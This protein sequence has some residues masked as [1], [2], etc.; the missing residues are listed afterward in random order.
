ME[1]VSHHGCA[2][3]EEA[4]RKLVS[5]FVEHA[6]DDALPLMPGHSYFLVRDEK[7]APGHLR[8]TLAPLLRE[9]LAQGYV[10]GFA[11]SIRGYLQWLES[12]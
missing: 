6:S 4:F 12:R 11:E 5:I 10:T 8:T 2:L 1:A 7:A 3:T 9:Y